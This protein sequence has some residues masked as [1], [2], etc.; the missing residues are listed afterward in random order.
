MHTIVYIGV[1]FVKFLLTYRV[2]S[3]SHREQVG[4]LN[5]WG[6]A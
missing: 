2:E 3:S 5:I 1:L 6:K 4:A